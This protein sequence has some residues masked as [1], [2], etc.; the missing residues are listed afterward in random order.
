[1][2]RN[3]PEII[4]VATGQ[5]EEIKTRISETAL[6]DTDKKIILSI[7]SVYTWLNNQLQLKKLSIQRLK[8]IFNFK[9]EKKSTSNSS[10]NDSAGTIASNSNDNLDTSLLNAQGDQATPTK[11]F[12]TG[13]QRKIMVE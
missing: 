5:L 11:K 6:P 3:M 7:L 2:A 8:T 4:T 1:M 9:T 12:L 13:I 10:N